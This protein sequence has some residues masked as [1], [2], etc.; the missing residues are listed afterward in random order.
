MLEPCL[1]HDI[2]MI[3]TRWK[4]VSI[5]ILFG[6]YCHVI[7]IL[8][9]YNGNNTATISTFWKQLCQERVLISLKNGWQMVGKCLSNVRAMFEHAVRF[10]GT[11]Y[12]A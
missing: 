1:Y 12:A 11:K 10:D 2:N 3:Q 5:A 7:A 4:H 8:L 9:R 6:Y